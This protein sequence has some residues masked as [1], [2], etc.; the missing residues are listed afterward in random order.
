MPAH[1]KI[2]QNEIR[3]RL[4]AAAEPD[5]AKF[6]AGL[7][8]K[9]GEEIPSGTAARLLGVRLPALRRIAGQ[10][11]KKNWR[12]SLEA[13]AA[14]EAGEAYFEEIMLQGFL[15]GCARIQNNGLSEPDNS[16]GRRRGGQEEIALQEQFALIRAF[17]PRIDNWSLCDSFCVGLKF[18]KEYPGRVWDFL[19][20]LLQSEEEFAVRFALVMILNY[21]MNAEYIDRL[22]PV[23]DSIR[24][25]G[26]YVKM[27]NAWALSFCYVN[28]PEKT[29]AYLKNSALDDFTFNKALQKIVESRCISQG[30]REH[31]K[32]MKR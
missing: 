32:K 23:F 11:A 7:L 28:F 26:Y 21:F 4:T 2:V 31:I 18:A 19:Q 15:I 25:E 5:Y 10:L 22:F 9:P 29:E 20:P 13:L 17:L 8:R 3:E 16:A 14:R 6:A 30:T 27:A 12:G 24:H 1:L